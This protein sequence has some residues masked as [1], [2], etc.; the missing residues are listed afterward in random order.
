M[1]ANNFNMA[2]GLYNLMSNSWDQIPEE[3][4]YFRVLKWEIENMDIMPSKKIMLGLHMCKPEDF[5]MATPEK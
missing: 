2:F 4:G 3:F 1:A 5:P